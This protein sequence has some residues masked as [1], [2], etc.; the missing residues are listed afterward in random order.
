MLPAPRPV[1]PR[2]V[3][4][5]AIA[6]SLA[7][8]LQAQEAVAGDSLRSL[9]AIVV[10]AEIAFR[11][12]SD[13]TA[14]VLV[15][16]LEFFQRFEPLTVGD[17]LKRVPGVVF[18]SDVL[19]FDGVQLRGLDPGYTQILINGKR[20]PGGGLDRSFFVDRIPAE[21]VDRIEIVRSQSANRSGDAVAGALNIVLRDAY[22]FDGAYVRAGLLNFRDGETKGTFGAV[23][24]GE[25]GGGRLLGGINVQ[26]RYNPKQKRSDRFDE[27]GGEFDNR[28]DQSD[29]RDGT[30]YS[31]NL[32]WT[33]E[34][35]DDRL[36]LSV[37]AVRT[38]REETEQ[39]FEY[40]DP[41]SSSRDNLLS[42]NDQFEDIDT[43]NHAFDVAYDFA[44]M[45]GRNEIS[46]NYASF[47]DEIVNTEIE[48]GFDDDDS[49][50]SFDETEGTRELFD[51]DDR[52]WSLAYSHKRELNAATEVEFGLQYNDKQR[53]SDLRVSEVASDVEGAPLP[54]FTDFD[55][56]S[57]KIEEQRLDPYLMFSGAGDRLSWEAGLRFEQTDVE[58]RA[59]GSRIENDY[60]ELLPSAHLNWDLDAENRVNASLARTVR[61]PG[62]DFL[63]PTLLE[64]EFGDNDF[65]G[66][67]RLDP[68]TAWGVDLGF[69]H[70]IGRRGVVGVNLFYRDITDLIELVN[71]GEP[72]DEALSDFDDEVEEFLEENPGADP[73]T[74]GFPEFDPNSFVYSAD[75]VGDGYVYGV[76]FDLSMPL[77]ALGLDSTGVFANYAWLDSEVEDDL[78]KRRFN[79]Q[80]RY[81]Y[82]VGFIQDL[83][84]WEASFGASYRKQGE[85]KL[86]VLAEEVTTNYGGDLE[87]FVEKRFGQRATLRLTA[88][89]L[90]D[91]SKDEIFN[92]FDNLADQIDRDFDEFELETEESG[93][94]YQLIGRISF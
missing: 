77:T 13:S 88:S 25:F 65:F 24:G 72:S 12:R 92:K 80:A 69:E 86:R 66:N 57:S 41:V 70:R 47:K 4:A 45:G 34:F 26:G 14:P 68:E 32:S 82:N 7:A 37:L 20:V 33:R 11:D 36:S 16:D 50:P 31:A 74:P 39:S 76:E 56:F 81:V 52:E 18:V 59:N 78:G 93:P 5:T 30:D 60:S 64:G 2:A 67:P 29:I 75:N 55:L 84:D 22:E 63:D 79:N 38:D 46:W 17:M 21:L 49:P 94:V 91:A 44:A 51:L 85:A 48:T 3:L 87:V 23:A 43:R 9:D 28:E 90:L 42:I 89:N 73:S 19:E 1:L 53:E 71:T 54:A 27:P 61:R 40:N 35:G 8:P 83:P 58:I 62:F 10:Q 15:Y 6:A